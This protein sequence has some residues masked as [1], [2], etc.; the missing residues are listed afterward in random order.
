[1]KKVLFISYA[2][3]PM[4]GGGIFRIVKFIKYLPDLG[5][6]PYV[7]T[8]DS[9]FHPFSDDTLIQEIPKQV[10]ITRVSYNE[11]ALWIK[12]RYWQSFLNM[13]W[14]PWFSISDKRITWKE[15]AIEKAIEIIKKE[16]I[17]TIFT[18][19]AS[20]TDHLIAYEVKKRTGVRWVADFRDEWASSNY[21]YFPTPLHAARVK[22][23]EK[24]VAMAADKITTVSP[25]LTSYFAKLTSQPDK[26]LTIT[27]GFDAEDFENKVEIPKRDYCQILYAGSLYGERSVGVFNQAIRELD[28]PDLKVDFFGGKN[29]ISHQEA[30]AKQRQA[31][32]LLLVLSPNDRP[33]VFTGKIF[34]YLA[35]RRPILALA[36]ETTAAAK[37]VRQLKVGEV[38]NPLD[39]EG[40]KVLV[41][42]FYKAWQNK[43]L[44]IAPIDLKPFERR[45]LTK[46]LAD[47]FTS[48]NP[49]LPKI[50]F[51]D[52]TASVQGV[53]LVKYLLSNG[54]EV[55][56]VSLNQDKIKGAINYQIKQKKLVNCCK[57]WYL[58]MGFINKYQALNDLKRII[59]KI[60]PDVI[61][62]HGVNFGGI[63]AVFSGFKPTVVTTRGSDI[64]LIKKQPWFEQLLIKKTIQKTQIVTGNSLVLK[65]QALSLGVNSSHWREVYIGVDIDI[66]KKI[67]VTELKEKY[68]SAKE[69]IIFCPRSIKPIYNTDILIKALAK[70][71]TEN[72]KLILLGQNKDDH[73]F[74]TIQDL[75]KSFGLEEQVIFL[76]KVTPE[77]MAKLYNLADVV[78]SLAQS[79]GAASS[80]LEAMACESKIVISNVDFVKEW[81]DGK[82]WVVPI[83][84]VSVTTTALDQVLSVSKTEFALDGEKNR[85]IIIERAEMNA[86]FKKFEDI[87]KELTQ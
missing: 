11:P 77:E 71:Q 5:I 26:C 70:L 39:K 67:G 33:A 24:M 79:D 56:F 16:Q 35:A 28:L 13:V 76:S 6:L 48:F 9:H 12:N 75:I 20:A 82:F 32:I 53:Q 80:F 60:K 21:Y 37:L 78:V 7:L 63:L 44:S 59:K 66:F 73:Y 47:I 15:T 49:V 64:L 36:P 34:E 29:L 58:L 85:Q 14:Y 25:P 65:N 2:F 54:Y 84:D 17:D 46:Q 23:L 74:S 3:P 51:I 30:I 8:V 27:N 43:N 81:Q 83:G 45:S 69:K 19:F 52:N 68:S 72:W 38:V 62:G 22:K 42:K 1:V 31:D 40:I 41:L 55:H 18:S 87:Y 50:L 57:P 4:A 86:C 10:Q 61:H